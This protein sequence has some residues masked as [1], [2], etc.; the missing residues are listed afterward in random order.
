[1]VQLRLAGLGIR[2]DAK[3]GACF[4]PQIIGLAGMVGGWVVIRLRVRCSIEQHAVG[5]WC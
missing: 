4:Q 5:I 1:M 2:K 3:I